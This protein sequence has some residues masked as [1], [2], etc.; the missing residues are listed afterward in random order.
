[1]F[2]VLGERKQTSEN[3]VY[4]LHGLKKKP[5]E[6]S[7]MPST[8]PT[9]TIEDIDFV[10]KDNPQA[11]PEYV[12]EIYAY[13]LEQETRY[14]AP[15]DYL[16]HQPAL[17]HKMRS[18]LVD[19]ISEV[20]TRLKL[21]NESFFHAVT[22]V[23]RFLAVKKVAKKSL[24]LVGIASLLIASKFEESYTPS[25][26]DFVYM[27]GEDSYSR[28]E[29]LDMERVI[30]NTLQFT[31]SNPT[32]ITFLR[33]FARVGSMSNRDR[34]LAFFLAELC[35]IEYKMLRY[36]P[37]E[38]AATCVY[39]S[40]K[41]THARHPW[42]ATLQHYCGYTES[43]LT[44]CVGHLENLIVKYNACKLAAMDKKYSKVRY[45]RVASIIK[46]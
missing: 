13:L 27:G 29:L 20:H 28:A 24:Q 33:R 26:K 14:A 42:T 7:M 35:Q 16:D 10:D 22:I 11:V 44:E 3:A 19:W 8:E 5:A 21:A 30:L 23:D 43:D 25:V 45:Y 1:M 34:Y 17:T 31:L 12:K 32:A 46:K 36:K 4:R 37:S 41:L 18:V 9:E 40:H 39:Y 2:S 38:V 6:I 15:A